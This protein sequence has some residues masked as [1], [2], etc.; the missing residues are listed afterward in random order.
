M[1]IDIIQSYLVLKRIDHQMQTINEF[2]KYMN[3]IHVKGDY[4]QPKRR[5]VVML[6]GIKGTV[7]LNPG[8]MYKTVHPMLKHSWLPV[9]PKT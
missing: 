7:W 4:R 1:E 2:L 9:M 3:R 5:W 8:T 6:M